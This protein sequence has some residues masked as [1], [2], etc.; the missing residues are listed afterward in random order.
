MNY[1]YGKL[2]LLGGDIIITRYSLSKDIQ[3]GKGCKTVLGASVLNI[4][5]IFMS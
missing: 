5:N 1:T 2:F 3:Y 4:S